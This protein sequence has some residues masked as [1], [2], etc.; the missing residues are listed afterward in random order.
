MYY[1]YIC[2]GVCAAPVCMSVCLRDVTH[3]HSCATSLIHVCLLHKYICMHIHLCIYMY[4]CVYM[5]VNVCA[6]PK[7]KYTCVHV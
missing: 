3:S 6:P 1:I 2:V 4:V 5:Y 7:H